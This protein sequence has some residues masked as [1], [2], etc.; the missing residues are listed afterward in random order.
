MASPL[1]IVTFGSRCSDL[2]RSSVQSILRSLPPHRKREIRLQSDPRQN[3][4]LE[5]DIYVRKLYGQD[6]INYLSHFVK[7][8]L[9]DEYTSVQP[10]SQSLDRFAYPP[11]ETT[12]KVITPP[13][14]G[15]SRTGP[16]IGPGAYYIPR[17][18]MPE[19][20]TGYGSKDIYSH[21]Y[22]PPKD[23]K[24]RVPTQIFR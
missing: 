4:D 17:T 13:Y 2:T 16:S 11:T 18:Y 1:Q 8:S 19:E 6:A 9:M 22:I 15:A 20:G 3:F 12:L 10:P 7:M 24:T 14:S 21:R 23:E 5:V